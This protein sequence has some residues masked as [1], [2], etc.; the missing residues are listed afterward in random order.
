MV[1]IYT[2]LFTV[3]DLDFALPF[4]K[5][6]PVYS[7]RVTFP[8]QLN[9][10]TS[11]YDRSHLDYLTIAVVFFPHLF[12]LHLL[13]S[14]MCLHAVVAFALNCHLYYLHFFFGLT[15]VHFFLALKFYFYFYLLEH[16]I[17]FYL[18][19]LTQKKIVECFH[20]FQML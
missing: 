19:S 20:L 2:K 18:L 13:Y 17:T 4:L 7:I 6:V 10:S 11:F 5:D 1:L 15:F 3:L 8:Y 9:S 14:L 16:Y 12:L